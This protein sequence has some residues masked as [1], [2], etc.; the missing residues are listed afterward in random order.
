MVIPGLAQ[1]SARSCLVGR[2]PSRPDTAARPR[3]RGAV[4]AAA[5][6]GRG[7]PDPYALLQVSRGASR[8]AIRAAYIERIKLLHPDV[9]PPG[10]DTTAAAAA[11]NAAYEALMDGFSGSWDSEEEEDGDPLSVFDQPEAEPDQLFVNPF[12]VYNISPLQWEELQAAARAAEAAGQDPWSALQQQGVQCSEGAFVYLSPAQLAALEAELA[13]ASAA[14][15]VI[16]MEAAAY[17]VSD[18]LLRARVA[19]NR[20]PTSAGRWG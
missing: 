9:S 1:Q 16:R 2:A 11:L 10:E 4:L 14:M 20:M 6:G 15:D 18:C 7:E 17:F 13:T 12:A 8:R 3:R 5:A 19:N